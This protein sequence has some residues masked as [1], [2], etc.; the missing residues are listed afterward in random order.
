QEVEVATK[1]GLKYVLRV[2]PAVPAIG[3]WILSGRRRQPP[4]YLLRLNQQVETPVW[5]VQFDQ[6]A[7]AH[8]PER[9]ARGRL[10]RNVDNYG[11]QRGPPHPRVADPPHVAN[12]GRE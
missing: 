8:R 11:S 3:P 7:I 1:L 9:P 10:R 4:S 12:A 2:E 6:V 5:K